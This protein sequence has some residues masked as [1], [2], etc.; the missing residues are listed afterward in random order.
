VLAVRGLVPG[1]IERARSPTLE[2]LLRAIGATLQI[3]ATW[4]VV[5]ALP[6][7]SA[8]VYFRGFVI[9]LG[10]AA[11]LRANY[12]MY[13]AYHII[14]RRA[15]ATGIC[16]STL[17]MQLGRRVLLRSSL[18]SGVL[19]VIAADIDI[20]APRLQ[21]A[22]ETYLPFVLAIP[23]VS[24][25]SFI[26]EAL[27]A[28]NRTLFGSVVGSYVLNIS[29]LLAVAVAPSN[30]SLTLYSWM[31]FGGSVV[32]A[33]VA[34]VFGQRALRPDW[35]YADT[36]IPREILREADERSVIGLA[37]AAM[38]WGPLCI[39]AVSAGA[40]EMAYYAVAARTAMILDLILPALNLSGGRD[41]INDLYPAQMSRRAIVAQLCGA[42]L[43]SSIVV[44]IALI[45]APAT[46][47]LYG[48][49]Y[50]SQ[51]PVY[52]L[53]LAV[54]WANSVGRPA[55]RH[56]VARWDVGRIGAA[57]GTAAVTAL[58]VC[59]LAINS[60]G[61][62]APAAASLISAL[63][64]SSWGIVAVVGNRDEFEK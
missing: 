57:V 5:H 61:I 28:A 49:P 22:L 17:I 50:D 52:L 48:H 32:A 45:A 58:L 1:E 35:H 4:A 19:L 33:A 56:L 30:A 31:Y 15:V 11:F 63:L 3:V 7:V 10:F 18:V 34:V 47:R 12:E 25:S 24:L 27:R 8:G 43:Y 9:S 40:Q 51:L 21:P 20:Q 6:P 59:G 54:Q 46:L 55:I 42:L 14:G 26:S 39:L 53:L 38:L 62:L 23:W 60:F 16:D 64:I 36:P 41:L 13:A 2:M 37:R 29:I 44:G